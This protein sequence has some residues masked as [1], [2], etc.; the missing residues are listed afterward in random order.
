[1]T[2][3]RSDEGYALLAAI[4]VIAVFATLALALLGQV[5]AAL[6]QANAEIERAR[7]DAAADAGA[8]LA[9]R[10]LISDDRAFRWSL[11]GRPHQLTF[12]GSRLTVRLIEERSKIPLLALEEEQ[13]RRLFELLK[14]P[15]D[16][17]DE[18]VDS[19]LD[20]T[21]DDDEPRP[22]GAEFAY[23]ARRHIHPRNAPPQ[24]FGELALVRGFTPDLVE[25]LR[26]VATLHFGNGPFDPHHADPIALG[27][28]SEG[29]EDSPEAIEREREFAG[30]RTAI[31][32]DEP[33]TPGRTVELNVEAVTAGG[34]RSHLRRLIELTGNRD[35][36][37]TVI[38][39]E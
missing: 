1:M 27:V 32:L 36:P 37:Y 34:G 5:Q 13:V 26:A 19:Y 8:Q 35:R 21:D 39:A 31:E 14:V 11:D 7:A 16:H 18:V 17:L 24:S 3:A 20:W 22:N 15:G 2:D 25:R 9:I 29:G 6:V 12:A 23:Y 38:E 33:A 28:M 30:Q 10:N 4:A